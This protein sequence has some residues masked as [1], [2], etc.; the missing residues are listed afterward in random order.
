MQNAKEVN[1]EGQSWISMIC[2]AALAQFL[3]HFYRK[4]VPEQYHYSIINIVFGT[5][6]GICIIGLLYAW[7]LGKVHF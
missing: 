5:A 6:F 7:H 2:A 4:W 1:M 3:G